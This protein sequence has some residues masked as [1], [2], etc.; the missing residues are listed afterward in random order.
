MGEIYIASKKVFITLTK[1]KQTLPSKLPL[2]NATKAYRDTLEAP[3]VSREVFSVD[4][5]TEL[6]MQHI[7][8][9][10]LYLQDY[11]LL[12]YQ[13]IHLLLE[14]SLTSVARSPKEKLFEKCNSTAQIFLQ[15]FVF[16]EYK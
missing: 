4:Y 15:F 6:V 14:K 16:T 7:S 2:F 12:S 9:H 8:S 5:A 10:P 11:L 13:K 3:F 1:G